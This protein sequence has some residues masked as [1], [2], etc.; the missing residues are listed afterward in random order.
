VQTSAP[1]PL[2]LSSTAKPPARRFKDRIVSL[3][4]Q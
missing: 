1:N 2:L 4:P 3:P